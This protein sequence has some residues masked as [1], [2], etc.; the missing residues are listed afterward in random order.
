[1]SIRLL[2][3]LFGVSHPGGEYKA[4]HSVFDLYSTRFMK[5]KS[6]DKMELC[7]ICIELKCHGGEGKKVWLLM[8][9]SVFK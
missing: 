5:G 4:P 9:F 8:K 1:M 6:A 2:Y 7:P 3:A